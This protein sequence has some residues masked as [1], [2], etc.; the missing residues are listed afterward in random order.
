MA[1]MNPLLESDTVRGPPEPL[2]EFES[3]LD[4]VPLLETETVGVLF[5]PLLESDT[6]RGPDQTQSALAWLV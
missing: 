4:T 6:V 1:S 3:L 2:L 5:E